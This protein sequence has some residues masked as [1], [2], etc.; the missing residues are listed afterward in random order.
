MMMNKNK[1]TGGQIAFAYRQA[2]IDNSVEQVFRTLA[3]SQ[4]A[5]SDWRKKY[6]G[7]GISEFRR[8]Q[9]LQE[10]NK[11]LK[12]LVAE[13]SLDKAMLQELVKKKI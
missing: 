1:S 2:T 12:E 6:S 13:L 9:R 11:K 3:I 8:L 4:P 7:V 10:E 5:F